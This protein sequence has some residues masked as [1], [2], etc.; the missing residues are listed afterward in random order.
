ME[1]ESLQPHN[2]PVV[3]RTRSALS[4][5]FYPMH[6]DENR[7]TLTEKKS[8]VIIPTCFIFQKDIHNVLVYINYTIPFGF[9]LY[10]DT[11][12][13]LFGQRSLMRV[14]YQKCAYGPYWWLF[15]F[16]NGVYISVEVSFCISTT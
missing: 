2:K 11:F 12:G 7:K 8:F 3:V 13:A 10:L 4:W 15:R 5:D 16:K 9:S 1:E 6:D 14:Q